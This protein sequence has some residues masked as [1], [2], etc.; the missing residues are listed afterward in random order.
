[1]DPLETFVEAN[2]GDLDALREAELPPARSPEALVESLAATASAHDA[3]TT[4]SLPGLALW[5]LGRGT[6]LG[7]RQIAGQARARVP[8]AIAHVA[9]R[10]LGFDEAVR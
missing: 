10:L 8:L 4:R 1:G 2:L 6:R 5:A 9:A 3:D 7:A